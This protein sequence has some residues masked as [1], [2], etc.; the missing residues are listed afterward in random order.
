MDLVYLENNR[1]ERLKIIGGRREER[2]REILIRDSWLYFRF[3]TK[4][5]ATHAI[6]AVHNTD[7]N[8]QTVKCSWGKE[9][10]DPNNAQQTGQVNVRSFI[11]LSRKR[12]KAAKLGIGERGSDFQI[13]FPSFRSIRLDS[14]REKSNFENFARREKKE[15]TPPRESRKRAEERREFKRREGRN[16]HL[17]RRNSRSN[18]VLTCRYVAKD[19]SN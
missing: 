17:F 10:G 13:E 6:V 12:E 19:G 8:G 5:S 1:G 18:Y 16:L 9:S 4:E 7:I 11:E 2:K 3:S 15:R 14:I